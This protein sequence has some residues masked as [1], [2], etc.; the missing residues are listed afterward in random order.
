MEKVLGMYLQDFSWIKGKVTGDLLCESSFSFKNHSVK[1][2]E[3]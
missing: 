3:R 2:K 1:M